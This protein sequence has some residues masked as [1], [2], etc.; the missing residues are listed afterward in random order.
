MA[1]LAFLLVS[2]KSD[3]LVAPSFG[4]VKGVVKD[5]RTRE[6]MVGVQ[7]YTAPASELVLTNEAGEY[8]L[9]SVTPGDYM[10]KA[11]FHDTKF[12]GYAS[13]PVKVHSGKETPA[14]LVLRIG[15][16]VRGTIAGVVN[17]ERGQPVA[18]AIVST[19]PASTTEITN[20]QG[21]FLL[22]DTPVDS[23][24]VLAT[25]HILYG[26]ETVFVQKDAISTVAVMIYTQDPHR[27]WLTGKV[28]SKGEPAPGAVVSI[29]SIGM[30][31]T[32]DAS[33]DYRIPNVPAGTHTITVEMESFAKNVHS[34]RVRAGLGTLINS[35]LHAPISIPAENLELYLPLNGTTQDLSP[36]YHLMADL[37]KNKYVADRFGRSNRAIEFDGTNGITTTDGAAMNFKPVTMGAWIYIPSFAGNVQL[38]L[39]KTPHPS[40]DGYYVVLENNKLIFMYCTNM[41]AQYSRTEIEGGDFP[42]DKWFWM[43]FA[44][45]PNGAGYATINGTTTKTITNAKNIIAN[46]QQF[47]FGNLPTTTND[48]GLVGMMDQVVIYSSFKSVNEL[49]TIMEQAD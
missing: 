35:S 24:V 48:L 49:K 1:V 9:K 23:V 44:V 2:C 41:F 19:D 25:T 8:N 5:P 27:G 36:Q 47:T 34:A 37:A 40:G 7:V 42:Y 46:S 13:M 16:P 29:S 4:S 21:E 11:V 3:E 14:D 31:D 38:I 26:Q 15:S 18:G 6:A 45:D 33:G 30:S 20:E 12:A 22:L 32:T 39:G 43:G 10:L 28:T 17:D